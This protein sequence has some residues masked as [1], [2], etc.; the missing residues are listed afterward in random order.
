MGKG[1][2]GEPSDNGSWFPGFL[3]KGRGKEAGFGRKSPQLQCNS[4][5]NLNEG[6][7]WAKIMCWAQESGC[8]NSAG[9]SDGL[10]ASWGSVNLV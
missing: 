7:P 8:R 6:S 4:E 1:I 10:G 2:Q 9:F 3:K 5:K